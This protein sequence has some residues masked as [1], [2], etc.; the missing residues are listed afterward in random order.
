MSV[1][2][3]ATD[4]YWTEFLCFEIA[5]FECGYNTIIGRPGLAK[6]TAILHYPY[7]I[8]KMPRP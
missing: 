7:M 2:F 3:G 8:L 4:N 1:T 5:G 6:F